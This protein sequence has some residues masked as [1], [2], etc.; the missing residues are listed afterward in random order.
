MKSIYNKFGFD[1]VLLTPDDFEDIFNV[2]S[3]EL[4]PKTKNKSTIGRHQRILIGE[5]NY[6]FDN[7]TYYILGLAKDGKLIGASMCNENND[8][9]WLGHLTILN[10]YRNSK[11][12]IVFLHYILNILFKDKKVEMGNERT[13]L[14]HNMI[15]RQGL[16]P[17]IVVVKKNIG[18][19]LQNIINKG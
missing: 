1:I 11:A 6:T 9:P 15:E 5:I 13:I 10:E 3:T 8:V 16:N 4:V 14:Y 2:F 7:P 19:R 12:F 18:L 17:D